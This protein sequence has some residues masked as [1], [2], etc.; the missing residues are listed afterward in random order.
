MN[1]SCPTCN[2]VYRVDPTKVPPGGVRARCTICR[3]VF[4]VSVG[5]EAPVTPAPPPPAT[6]APPAPAVATAQS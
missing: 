2:T 6:A 4:G 1:V 3:A 5:G